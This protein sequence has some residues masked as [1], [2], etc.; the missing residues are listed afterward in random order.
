MTSDGGPAYTGN[1]AM[2]AVILL[3]AVL[4]VL[5]GCMQGQQGAHTA[6]TTVPVP[7]GSP[8]IT[9]PATVVIPGAGSSTTAA[10]NSRVFL[11]YQPRKCEKTPWMAWE[12]A[13]GRRYIRAPAEE[14]IIA[15][16]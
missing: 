8:G 4:A 16:Y 3:T 13:S 12:E 7:E 15:H 9:E 2:G 14:E 1:R 10:D 6:I 5:A 11:T